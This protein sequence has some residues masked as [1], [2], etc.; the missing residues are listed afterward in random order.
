[1]I[2]TARAAR[3]PRPRDSHL[4]PL[5]PQQLAHRQFRGQLHIAAL[6]YDIVGRVELRLLLENFPGL[7]VLALERKPAAWIQRQLGGHFRT[8]LRDFDGALLERVIADFEMVRFSLLVEG[9]VAGSVVEVGA[10]K[11]SRYVRS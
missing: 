7:R 2:N 9:A 8:L 4:P 1:M 5:N 3:P 10:G 6:H 11:V